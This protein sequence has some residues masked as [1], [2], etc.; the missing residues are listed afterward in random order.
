MNDYILKV[1]M[2]AVDANGDEL[3]RAW[4]WK[5]VRLPCCPQ[6]GW[7]TYVHGW[8]LTVDKISVS[9]GMWAPIV[10]TSAI[11]LDTAAKVVDEIDKLLCHCGFKYEDEFDFG[12]PPR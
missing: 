1:S 4:A 9:D 2:F 11:R 6:I 8:E 3:D 12:H 10:E 7:L 5:W